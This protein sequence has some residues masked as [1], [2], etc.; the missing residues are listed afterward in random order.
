MIEII[1]NKFFL[2]MA[3]GG[4]MKTKVINFV[5]RNPMSVYC[6][7]GIFLLGL[8]KMQT[9]MAYNYWFGKQH[10]QRKLAK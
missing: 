9:T 3:G 2:K 1:I 6:S 10:F 7:A 8:R 4:G 5:V